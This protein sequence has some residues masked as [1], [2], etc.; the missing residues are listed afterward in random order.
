MSVKIISCLNTGDGCMSLYC[1]ICFFG[2]E[3]DG[4]ARKMSVSLLLGVEKRLL[5]SDAETDISV[6]V[7]SRSLTV[8][9]VSLMVG[10]RSLT[11]VVGS[12]DSLNV[13]AGGVGVDN[14]TS[15][16]SELV[17]GLDG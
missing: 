13:C 11:G 5:L 15:L 16:T 2:V 17:G 1:F 9:A 7:M 8:I 3:W 14:T 6:G 10:V 12:L 4:P